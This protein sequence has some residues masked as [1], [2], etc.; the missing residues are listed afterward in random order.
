[1]KMYQ[2]STLQALAMGYTRSVTTVGELRM[3]GNI[4]LG[5]F[6][7]VDGEMILVDGKCY[8]AMETGLVEEADDAMGVPFSSVVTMAETRS[9]SIGAMSNIEALK[10]YLTVKIEEGFGLNS[11]HVIRIDGFFSKVDARS[12]A[13]Y[14][15]QHITLKEML[16]VTQRAFVFEEIKGTMVC[17]YYPDYMDGINAAGWHLHFISND[18]TKGGHVFDLEMQSG[19][20]SL[21]KIDSIEIQMPCDPAFDTYSLKESSQED[22]KEVEQGSKIQKKQ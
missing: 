13:P 2:V 9:F 18:R 21:M 11:M 20:A 1:M 7:N 3:H 15:S 8:R 17:V 6:E 19:D 12:E 14:R 10:E 22:I 5:T 4:G 16:A